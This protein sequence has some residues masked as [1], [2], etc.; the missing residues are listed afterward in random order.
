MP[1]RTLARAGVLAGTALAATVGLFGLAQAQAAPQTSTTAN[2]MASSMTM[3]PSMAM[4][5]NMSKTMGMN[6][7]P[8]MPIDTAHAHKHMHMHDCLYCGP[9]CAACRDKG[10]TK[11]CCAGRHDN[12]TSRDMKKSDCCNGCDGCCDDM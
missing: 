12:F 7:M 11:S 5:M 2:C 10:C 9:Q 1:Q 6:G 4:G 8:K 3:K